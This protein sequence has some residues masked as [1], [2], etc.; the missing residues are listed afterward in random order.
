[1]QYDTKSDYQEETI[2][3]FWVYNLTNKIKAQSEF[4]KFS[5][6]L[7]WF[8]GYQTKMIEIVKYIVILSYQ[9]LKGTIIYVKMENREKGIRGECESERG[10]K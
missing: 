3:Y 2:K 10:K 8:L 9:T 7:S 6:I 1:M 5:F 4:L